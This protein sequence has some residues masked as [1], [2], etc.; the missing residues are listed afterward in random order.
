M[1]AVGLFLQKREHAGNPMRHH[2]AG[3]EAPFRADHQCEQS[4]PG[5]ADGAGGVIAGTFPNQTADRMRVNPEITEC[6][7]LDRIQKLLVG[8]RRSPGRHRVRSLRRSARFSG[9]TNSI[10]ASAAVL[11]D[12]ITVHI[13]AMP[14]G[15]DGERPLRPFCAL[16][17]EPLASG[18]HRQPLQINAAVLARGT[19]RFHRLQRI[20]KTATKRQQ[21]AASKIPRLHERYGCSHCRGLLQPHNPIPHTQWGRGSSALVEIAS[22]S[23]GTGSAASAGCSGTFAAVPETAYQ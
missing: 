14:G 5:A 4:E 18:R 6:R 21:T 15:N 22:P 23:V 9:T 12:E 17:R 2:G 19:E 8:H 11:A 10:V 7:P 16:H 13:E 3:R 20:G 1:K